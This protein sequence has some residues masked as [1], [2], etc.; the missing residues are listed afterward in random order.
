MNEIEYI[1]YKLPLDFIVKNSFLF[2]ETEDLKE[3]YKRLHAK[4]SYEIWKQA[5]IYL[6]LED[7]NDI[8]ELE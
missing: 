5:P 1:Q 7:S 2:I 4:V 8:V 3:I 6:N